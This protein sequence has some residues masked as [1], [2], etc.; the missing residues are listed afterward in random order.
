MEGGCY[1]PKTSK[2]SVL[3]H[4][5][6]KRDWSLDVIVMLAAMLIADTDTHEHEDPEHPFIFTSIHNNNPYYAATMLSDVMKKVS[7]KVDG[8][9]SKSASHDIRYGALAD[10]QSNPDL[11][12]I[13]AIFRGDWA[14]LGDCTGLHY[15]DRDPGAIDAG[16]ALAGWKSLRDNIESL[17][18]MDIMD[19]LLGERVDDTLRTKYKNLV[20]SL[21]E[22]MP[23]STNKGDQCYTLRNVFFCAIIEKLPEIIKDLKHLRGKDSG[24]D[25]LER[26]LMAK[27]IEFDFDFLDLVDWSAK[28][29][30]VCVFLYY[31]SSDYYLLT[32]AILFRSSYYA[33]R[34]SPYKICTSTKLFVLHMRRLP[35]P[36]KKYANLREFL[37]RRTR[38]LTA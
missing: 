11:Q 9:T 2:V 22:G 3:P 6:D 38:S 37:W 27:F 8:L 29:R 18:A 19:Y 21:F 13:C 32:W 4:C 30:V 5:R 12:F 33:R 10:M 36:V 1:Q 14:F 35:I 20:A 31:L 15:A 17:D 16:K 25:V 24:K 26:N 34:N 23:F 7:D 28:V